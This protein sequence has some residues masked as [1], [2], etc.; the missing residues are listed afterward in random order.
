M[1]NEVG[2]DQ[3]GLL[4]QIQVEMILPPAPS[5]PPVAALHTHIQLGLCGYNSLCEFSSIFA[6]RRGGGGLWLEVLISLF[7]L[8]YFYA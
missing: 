5:Q 8:K 7:F 6:F 4:K 1:E 2:A 3:M